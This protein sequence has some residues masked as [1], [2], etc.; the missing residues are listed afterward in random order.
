MGSDRFHTAI[1]GGGQAGLAVNY[2]LG[3]HGCEHVI[4]EQHRVVE[5]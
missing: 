1:I 4:L 5:R 2:H 3:Q